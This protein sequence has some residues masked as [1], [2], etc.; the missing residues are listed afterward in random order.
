MRTIIVTFLMFLLAACHNLTAE[1]AYKQGH[2]LESISLLGQSIEEKGPDRLKA[3]DIQRLQNIVKNVMKNFEEQISLSSSTD[4]NQRILAYQNLKSMKLLLSDRFYSQ[5]IGFFDGKYDIDELEQTIAKEYYNY[6]NSIKGTNGESYRRRAELY[7][8]GLDNYNYKNIEKLYKSA[9][10]KYMQ[11][12]AKEYYD[13]GKILAKQGDYKGAAEAF[14]SASSVYKPIGKYK[15]SQKLA[16]DNDRKYCAQEAEKYYQQAKQLASTATRHYQYREVAK[17][18]AWAASAYEK[19]GPYRDAMSQSKKY[20]KEGIVKIYYNSRELSSYVRDI[21]HK[22]FIQFVIYNPGEADVIMR[23]KSNVEFSDLGQSVNNQTK[24]EK[25]FDKFIEVV[26]DS[27]NKKQVKTYKDQQYN[28]QTV[29]HSNKLTLT[30]EI[31]AHGAYSYSRSFNI[32]QTSARYD[33]IYSGNVPSKLRNYS[34]GSLQTRER[35]LELAQKQQ[36][37]EV[38]LRLEDILRDLSY[39]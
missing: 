5:Y 31:E 29:T 16:V 27:G 7:K 15:D 12:G 9:N 23:I 28:L 20:T 18:Y 21:L 6:G 38:K 11:I 35:L 13:Q 22:D 24:T 19:Y 8:R 14:E 30:T 34:E 39:L 32:E 3:E 25:V 33:Y 36:L 10:L 1:E 37:K 2:Y 26:D 17:Y 4:Y